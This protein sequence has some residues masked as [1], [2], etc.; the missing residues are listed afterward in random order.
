M[1]HSCRRVAVGAAKA[2]RGQ[3]HL[4]R[5]NPPDTLRQPR[6]CATPENI[7]HACLPRGPKVVGIDSCIVHRKTRRFTPLVPRFFLLLRALGCRRAAA[8]A[9][10]C[11]STRLRA[12]LA[13]AVPATHV[14]IPSLA[15]PAQ[16]HS[17]A[18]GRQARHSGGGVETPARGTFLCTCVL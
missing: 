15:K 18:A 12:S 16:G 11:L 6:A 4:I 9:V 3:Q 14:R 7:S 5:C 8:A 10:F 13:A 2:S 17:G 1:Y